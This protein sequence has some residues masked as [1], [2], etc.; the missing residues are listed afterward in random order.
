[1]DRGGLRPAG[2][3]PE[4]R[5]QIKHPSASVVP[6]EHAEG[7][8]RHLAALRAAQ[9]QIAVRPVADRG[10]GQKWGRWVPP[11]GVN[12]N[13]APA[14]S[15]SAFNVGRDH[16]HHR[17]PRPYNGQILDIRLRYKA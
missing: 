6:A 10:R 14:S 17:H 5:Y 12:E 1:M 4:L 7:D 3:A 2:L 15:G 11:L 8:D 13:R 9:L 16:G